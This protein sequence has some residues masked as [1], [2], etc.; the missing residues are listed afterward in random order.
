M[1]FFPFLFV[2]SINQK[3]SI[4]SGGTV[5]ARKACAAPGWGQSGWKA[6]CGKRPWGAGWQQLNMSQVGSQA[7][8]TWPVP[9]WPAGRGS[10]GPPEHKHYEEQLW[11]LSLE[12]RNLGGTLLLST[13][14]WQQGAAR[15]A[16]LLG[17]KWNNKRKGPH[18]VPGQLLV[19]YW[20]RFLH[21]K[22][23]QALEQAAQG[24][25]AVPPLTGFKMCGCGTEGCGLV[26]AC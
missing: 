2:F 8:G 23:G 15:W 22:G 11:G 20:E 16:L 17:N 4:R 19:G 13:A 14:P 5:Y 26:W 18:V 25:G 1:L 3:M 9:V 12:K 24:S 7:S 6:A 21:C 10:D